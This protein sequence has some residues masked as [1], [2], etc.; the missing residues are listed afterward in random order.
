[1]MVR[2]IMLLGE[3]GVGKTSIVRRLAFDKFDGTYKA[4][5]GTD[6]YRYEVEPPPGGQPFHFIVWDTDGNFGD[7][8]FKHVYVKQAHAA[9]IIGDVSR[10]TTLEH[11]VRLGEGFMD[12]L[13]GRPFSYVVNKIDL[14]NPGESINGPPGLDTP[15]FPIVKT[16][17]KTGEHVRQ[18]FHDIA[19][20][21]QR[22]G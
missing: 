10:R 2:K 9:L 11:M 19:T 22:R 17:A 12:A 1:M 4:T 21:I 16:S 8:I 13:P 15:E 18:A 5:L 14:L 7:S 6:V 3:I 20:I